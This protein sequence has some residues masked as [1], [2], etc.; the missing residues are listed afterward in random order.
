MAELVSGRDVRCVLDG[1]RT[2]DRCV[3]IC[4]PDDGRDIAE[5]TAGYE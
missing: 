3:A 1:E 2:R 4:Y 5:V